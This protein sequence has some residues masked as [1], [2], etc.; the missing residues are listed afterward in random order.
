MKTI[1]HDRRGRPITEGVAPDTRPM[2]GSMTSQHPPRF[3]GRPRPK[4][5]GEGAR[6][7]SR[8]MENFGGEGFG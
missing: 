6:D 3:G 4:V 5:P 8:G 7:W 1:L 2:T